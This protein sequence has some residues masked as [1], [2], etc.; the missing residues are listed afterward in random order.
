MTI[1]RFRELR[2]WQE[3]MDAIEEVHR[4][5]EKWPRHARFGITDQVRRAACSVAMNIAEGNCRS[6]RRD[7]AHFIAIAT[8]SA[9][10]TQ[11]GLLIGVRLGYMTAETAEPTIARLDS[12]GR[13]LRTLRVRLLDSRT[14]KP[15]PDSQSP[16]P[17]P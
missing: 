11:A 13:M 1:A 6:T 9:G 7:Y 3:A 16:I 14:D 4:L 15:G 10:E 5:T 8:G 17:N 2:V 12:I